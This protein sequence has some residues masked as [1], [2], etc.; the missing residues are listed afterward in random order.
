MLF[1]LETATEAAQGA[2]EWIIPALASRTHRTKADV[3]NLFLNKV[4]ACNGMF[5]RWLGD[6]E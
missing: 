2:E 3:Q 6:Q 4:F 1:E 5:T